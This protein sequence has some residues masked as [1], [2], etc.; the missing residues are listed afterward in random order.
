[1]THNHLPQNPLE[2]QALDPVDPQP[3][4]PKDDTP[5][6][7]SNMRSRW[8]K[9]SRGQTQAPAAAAPTFGLV[10]QPLASPKPRTPLEPLETTLETQSSE[11]LETH[12]SERTQ[13]SE[14]LDA[15]ASPEASPETSRKAPERPTSTAQARR[16]KAREGQGESPRRPSRNFE[17]NPHKLQPARSSF[18]K[19]LP[20]KEQTLKESAKSSIDYE[21]SRTN[22]HKKQSLEDAILKSQEASLWGKIKHWLAGLFSSTT[23]EKQEHRPATRHS[24]RPFERHKRPYY[25]RSR[26]RSRKES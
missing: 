19:P 26:H 18:S 3:S 23:V 6:K 16:P 15:P 2:T 24:H 8:K 4:S 22:L 11:R 17:S 1:M 20:R 21:P 10:E 9:R 5:K 13:S 14:R 7:N 25:G 12:N